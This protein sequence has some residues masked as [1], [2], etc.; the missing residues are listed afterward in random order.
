MT[1]DVTLVRTI[2]EWLAERTRATL[3]D[4]ASALLAHSGPIAPR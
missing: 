3:T 1:G 2:L 4:S